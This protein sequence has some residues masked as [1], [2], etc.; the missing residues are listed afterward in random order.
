VTTTILLQPLYPPHNPRPRQQ[1]SRLISNDCTGKTSR[2]VWSVDGPVVWKVWGVGAERLLGR[3]A[4]EK[5]EVNIEN[6]KLKF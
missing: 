4:D 3:L 6:A 1:R 5:R 2:A